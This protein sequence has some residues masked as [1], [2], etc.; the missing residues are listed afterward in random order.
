MKSQNLQSCIL[1]I[2][3]DEIIK[4]QFLAN[5]E[6]VL[7]RYSLTEQEKKAIF[8]TQ[9]RLGLVLGD[10]AQLQAAIDPLTIWL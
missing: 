5:P 10:S 7:S 9:A 2:Y 4:Q 1:E 8:T 6:G 3:G